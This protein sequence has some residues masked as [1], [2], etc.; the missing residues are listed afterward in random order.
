MLEVHR[1]ILSDFKEIG[2]RAKVILFGSLARGDYR[3]DSD[4]DLAVV[5]E[6]EQLKKRAAVI[7]DEALF[8]YGKVVSLTFL[9]KSEMQRES[10]FAQAI[11]EGKVIY[12]GGGA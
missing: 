7:A 1:K 5:T 3:L 8:E 6:K 12:Y 2:K 11:K 10:P 4:I 9:S